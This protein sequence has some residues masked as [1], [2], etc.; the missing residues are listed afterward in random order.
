MILADAVTLLA[1]PTGSLIVHLTLLASVALLASLAGSSQTIRPQWRTASIGVLVLRAAWLA[2]AGLSWLHVL[3]VEPALPLLER[4]IT[5]GALALFGWGALSTRNSRGVDRWLVALTAAAALGLLISALILRSAPSGRPFNRTFVDAAWGIA[6]LGLALLC[7]ALSGLWR[8]DG[9]R[10]A[11]A[12]FGMMAA[13]FALHLTLGPRQGAYPAYV[14]WAELAAYPMLIIAAIHTAPSAAAAPRPQPAP[15]HEAELA[16]L[17]TFPGVIDA[18]ARMLS[19]QSADEVAAAA[20]ESVARSMKAEICYILT[21]LDPS[22]YLSF[23]CGYDL[24]GE[25]ALDGEALAASQL[26]VIANAMLQKKA[27][28]LPAQSHAPDLATLQRMLS[29]PATGPVLM[30]P[31]LA[32]GAPQGGLLLL[33]PYA[34]RKWSSASQQALEKLAVLIADR[35][36]EAH[37]GSKPAPEDLRWADVDIEET[38]RQVEQ[39]VEENARLSEILQRTTSQIGRELIGFIESRQSADETIDTL[40]SEISRLKDFVLESAQPSEKEQIEQLSYQLQAVLEELAEARARLATNG[41]AAVPD[42]GTLADRDMRLIASLAQGLRQPMASILGYTDLLLSDA[43]GALSEAQRAY[44]DHIHRGTERLTSLLNNLIQI[45]AIQTGSLDLSPVAV[46]LRQTLYDAL[47][48]V[49]TSAEARRLHLDQ[50]IPDQLPKLLGDA[51]ALFQILVHLLNNAIGASPAEG[52]IF[53]RVRLAELET[54]GFLMLSVS[55]EGPGIPPE[56]LGRVF[57]AATEGEE[58]PIRGLGE[59]RL[60]LS[61]ARA[62]TEAMGGRIWVESSPMGGSTFTVLL[63]LAKQPIPPSNTDPGELRA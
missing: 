28:V 52:T 48:Q 58:Q 45:T 27:L 9:W 59:S 16:D 21:P 42:A 14:R 17:I 1:S 44:L 38:R 26:P 15:D 36:H 24:I 23:A 40:E 30:T 29:L 33:S 6:G 51:D 39:L 50:Q 31:L 35:L 47:S 41:T 19:A 60:G 13:G 61:I 55:D 22:G 34:R 57:D 62:L 56:D 46:D 20:A 10:P 3:Q 8:P 2:V 49:S 5:F 25:R 43:P 12:G 11:L 54:A 7:F 37:Q 18:L 63:P 4:F 32:D 53:L